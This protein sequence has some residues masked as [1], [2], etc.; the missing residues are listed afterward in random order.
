MMHKKIK[1]LA[2]CA[3]FTAGGGIGY[4]PQPTFGFIL[5]FSVFTFLTGTLKARFKPQRFFSFSYYADNACR[6]LFG[7]P[8]LL[9]FFVLIF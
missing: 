9:L 6:P 4:V 3:V 7:W 1:T 2:L 8:Y 5:G